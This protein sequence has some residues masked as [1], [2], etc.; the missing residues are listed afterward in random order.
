MISEQLV[1]LSRLQFA[2]TAMYHFLFVPVTIGLMAVIAVL[3]F[4][5]C[6]VVSVFFGETID[7]VQ[8]KTPE[9]IEKMRVAGRLASE[10]LDYIE[11]FIK[12]GAQLVSFHIE[13]EL[14]H[15]ALLANKDIDAVLISTPDHQHARLA[16]DAVRAGKLN[17]AHAATPCC[18][19]FAFTNALTSFWSTF[20]SSRQVPITAMSARCTEFMQSFGQP[21][22]LNLNLYGSAGRC[23][24]SV[25]LFIT[26][27]CARAASKQ[28]CSQRA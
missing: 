15:R 18:E 14:D 11:P 21:E 19:L 20:M 7:F 6:A 17:E 25:K 9:A 26:V 28:E 12:A 8:I 27:R 16:I 3:I 10:L 22:N 13:P 5:A 1:D 23:R 2:A 24:S 4:V